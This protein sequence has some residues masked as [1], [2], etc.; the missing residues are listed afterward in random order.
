M[1]LKNTLLI[2]LSFIAYNLPAQNV[3][4]YK[5]LNG[6]IDKYAITMHLHK[7]DHNFSGYYYYNSKQ[8]PIYFTGEDTTV[9]G[10]IK[11]Y[12]FSKST[13]P[14]N[15]E[16]LFS[17]DKE[18][19]SGQWKKNDSN[20]A[21]VFSAMESTDTSLVSFTMIYVHDETKLKPDMKESPAATYEAA[22]VWPKTESETA[23][24][25]KK[26]VNEEFGAKDQEG[27]IETILLKN[28]K[29]F[30]DEYKERYKDAKEEDMKEMPSAFSEEQSNRVMIVYQS[31]NILT[32][33]NFSYSYTGGAHGN[34]GTHYSS[35]DLLSKKI[36]KLDNVLTITGLA[37]L[38]V[39]LK[40]YF[41][42]NYNLDANASLKEAGLFEEKIKPNNNFYV[43]E[44]GIGFSYS[45]YEIGPYAMGEINIFIPFSELKTLLQPPFENLLELGTNN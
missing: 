21:L 5:C 44:K 30:F 11:L 14:N 13:D 19:C 26:F 2:I 3:N 8:E 7:T 1:K 18:K 29:D 16:F 32:L 25:I 39:L 31:K 38:P 36:L 6:T 12:A 10:K 33:G 22:S 40:K 34:Y 27:G 20:N 17:V 41:R 42:K 9:A 23:S 4:W 43:T 37:Q 15:E 28:K 35:F 45:P 24:F